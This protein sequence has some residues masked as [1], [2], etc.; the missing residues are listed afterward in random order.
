MPK[1][2][3]KWPCADKYGKP[4]S[5]IRMRSDVDFFKST[6]Q[7]YAEEDGTCHNGY[8]LWRDFGQ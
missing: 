1:V 8:L 7:L 2:V 3:K 6:K 5:D 4:R